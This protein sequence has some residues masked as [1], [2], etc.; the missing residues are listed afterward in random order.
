M[1]IFF[2][3]IFRQAGGAMLMILL[4]LGGVVWIALALKQL[5]VVTSQGQNALTFV[6]MTTL[7]LPH[8]LAVIAPFALLIACVHA[9]NRL[10]S[11][12][13]LIVMTASG[14]NP[15]VAGRPLLLL[16][17]IVTLAVASVS[18]F[19]MPWSLQLLRQYIVEVRTDLLTQVMQP[20]RFSSPES[21]LTFH[22][23]DRTFQGELLGLLVE[24]R[25]EAGES[26]AY[27]AERAK[28]VKQ[29]DATYMFMRDGHILQTRAQRT[30]TQI[31]KFD[32][33]IVDLDQ[34]DKQTPGQTVLKPKERYFSQLAYPDA[35]DPMFKRRPG[36]FRA[37]LH[38]RFSSP[39]YPLA[40]VLIALAC[41]GQARSTRQ[42]RMQGL[43]TAC[44]AGFG[45]RL[46]G[47][48]VNNLVA[49]DAT[50][51]PLMYAFPVIAMVMATVA[52]ALGS[53][54][55]R[56]PSLADRMSEMALA[57]FRRRKSAGEQGGA[58]GIAAA[59]G[60]SAQSDPRV[61]TG[62]AQ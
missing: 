51:I 39:L 1:S 30:G 35:D 61:P 16:G 54:P 36:K 32:Q 53:K 17:V 27:M 2:R 33:Y 45:C 9:L 15:W 56:G 50:F 48:A 29:D 26:R 18:H 46:G 25:R 52:I 62:L 44:V 19:V 21:G 38:E 12:S 59:T 11:D 8:L 13:E 57:V 3:Y 47:L 7:A 24:D 37:E 22:I 14:A 31:V 41:M 23:R 55:R 5:N 58:P 43:I 42:N 34:F 10:N 6:I 28:I 40:F 60:T 20:G 49:V 4:S